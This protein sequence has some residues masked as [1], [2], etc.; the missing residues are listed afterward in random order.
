[1]KAITVLIF[2][3]TSGVAFCQSETPDSLYVVTYTTGLNWDHARQPNEQTYFKEHS[4]H[5]SALRKAGT[6]VLGARYAEKGII[7]LKAQSLA[8]AREIIESDSAIVN[9][10]FVADVQKLSVFYP[11]CID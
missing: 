3:F 10:L 7:V 1:M 6:I 8:S 9:K 4:R 11:G 5:L 2:F